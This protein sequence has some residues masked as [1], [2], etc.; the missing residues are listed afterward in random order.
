MAIASNFLFFL[1]L[2]LKSLINI[3]LSSLLKNYKVKS[4]TLDND[5][6]F[7][8]WE[9]LEK[10]LNCNIYFTHP[11]HSW[12]KGL[13]ENM[14]RWIREFV[15]KTHRALLNGAAPYLELDNKLFV[16]GGFDPGLDMNK[17]DPQLLMWDRDLFAEAVR[18]SKK[19]PDHRFGKWEDIFI[20]HTPSQMYKSLEPIHACNVWDLDTGGGWSGKLTLMDMDSHEY[21][22]SDLVPTLYPNVAGRVA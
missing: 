16:H 13:V 19:N 14:N 15:P 2:N 22:Q 11:Y 12:E 10:Q 20:G 17:Q 5:I 6:A 9:S 8:N 18:T 21:W 7:Q 3:D 1:T 4:L